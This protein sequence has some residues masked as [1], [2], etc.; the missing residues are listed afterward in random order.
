M[1]GSENL[2]PQQ[3]PQVEKLNVFTLKLVHISD[4]PR[5]VLDGNKCTEKVPTSL[6]LL[7]GFHSLQMDNVNV[8]V[9]SFSDHCI[10]QADATGNAD[11]VPANDP[12]TCDISSSGHLRATGMSTPPTEAHIQQTPKT[13]AAIPETKTTAKRELYKEMTSTE[14]E[15]TTK[16][17]RH[18]K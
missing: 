13:I 7:I 15:E 18:E 17:L 11:N 4:I 12:C 6:S 16:K 2:S 8:P 14:K 9:V 5:C 3:P 1:V 10:P